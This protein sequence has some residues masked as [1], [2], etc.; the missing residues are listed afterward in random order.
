MTLYEFIKEN[1]ETYKTLYLNGIVTS[2]LIMSYE[3]YEIYLRLKEEDYK[4]TQKQASLIISRRHFKGKIT[5][6]GVGKKLLRMK[7]EIY[8]PNQGLNSIT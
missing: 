8:T 6:K 7:K 5:P 4:M 2:S 3:A 1:Y